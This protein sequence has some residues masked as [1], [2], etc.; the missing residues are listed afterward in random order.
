MKS[1]DFF[2]VISQKPGN[3]AAPEEGGDNFLIVFVSHTRRR[4]IA[5]ALLAPSTHICQG[6]FSLSLSYHPRRRLRFKTRKRSMSC[7]FHPNCP[8][9]EKYVSQLGRKPEMQGKHVYNRKKEGREGCL[10]EDIQFNS[11]TLSWFHG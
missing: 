4:R 9:L 2:G 3:S 5:A 7:C 11:Q 6:I 1:F 8:K 10:R